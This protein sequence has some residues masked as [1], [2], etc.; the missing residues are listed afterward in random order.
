[1]PLVQTR[2][3]RA[4]EDLR[5]RQTFSQR[6]WRD[7]V[8]RVVTRI[9]LTTQ[10]IEHHPDAIVDAQGERQRLNQR[11]VMAG[12]AGRRAVSRQHHRDERAL[13]DRLVSGIE[14]RLVADASRFGVGYVALDRRQQAVYLALVGHV[15][16]QTPDR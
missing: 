4:L 13:H 12:L 5:L 1:M 15:G 2:Q 6:R 7:R 10:A 11:L 8:P 3:Q 9:A 16:F 14:A